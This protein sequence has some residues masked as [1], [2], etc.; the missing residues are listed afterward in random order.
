MVR[1]EN[2]SLVTRVIST[3]LQVERIKASS[4]KSNPKSFSNI[5][6]FSSS[7]ENVDLLP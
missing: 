1:L 5:A 4:I 2:L 7:G 3:L 6:L